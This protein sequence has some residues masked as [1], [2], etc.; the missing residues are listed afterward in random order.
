MGGRILVAAWAVLLAGCA[1][2]WPPE[3]VR[4]GAP[5]HRRARE[6]AAPTISVPAD[7]VRAAGYAVTS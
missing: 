1:S 6:G 3:R 4:G 5:L 7:I 2:S